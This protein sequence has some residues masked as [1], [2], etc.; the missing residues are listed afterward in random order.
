MVCPWCKKAGSK[1]VDSRLAVKEGVRKRRHK[2]EHCNRKFTTLELT[3][4][5][6]DTLTADLAL[7]RAENKT[8][9]DSFELLSRNRAKRR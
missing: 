1:V 8:L 7:A 2:C 4:D 3:S 5:A 6:Y 9:L